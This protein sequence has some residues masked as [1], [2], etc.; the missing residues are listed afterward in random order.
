[1]RTHANW[2]SRVVMMVTLGLVFASAPLAQTTTSVDTRNFEVITVDGNKL[3]FKD[4]RGTHEL[5]VP[6]DFRFTVD[7]KKMAVGELKPGMKGTATVTTTTTIRPVVITE[8]R[9]AE[10]L[11]ASDLSVSIRQG[12]ESRRWTQGDLD[13]QGIQIYRDGK[14]V[15]TADLKRGDKL[16]ATIVTSGAP[17]VLTEQEVQ[18]ALSDAPA[19]AAPAEPAKMAAATPAQP[20]PA[21]A[22]TAAPTPPPATTPPAPTP[23][24]AS[25][26]STTWWLIIAILIGV[27]LFVFM[28]RKKQE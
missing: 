24:A 5:T 16:T 18:A 1:M 14:A 4:E 19:A 20:A 13:K 17:V 26:I 2:L 25:G 21:A 23:P 8:V 15:R 6:A 27:I 7:G 3:I 9:E 22:P 12:N 11:R 28:R 10:V